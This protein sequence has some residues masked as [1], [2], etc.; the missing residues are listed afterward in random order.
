ML[1]TPILFIIFNRPE[2]TKLVF[3]II[4]EA[5]PTK[6]YVAS[7][8]PRSKNSNDL[9]LIEQSRQIVTAVD[10]KCDV[11]TLFQKENLGCGLGPRTAFQWFFEHEKLGIILEDD[12]LP[13]LD[14]FN[15]CEEM[16]DRYAN[17]KKII[18]VIGSN[19]GYNAYNKASYFFSRY[20]NT[21]GWATWKDRMLEIDFSISDWQKSK[22]KRLKAIRLLQRN[23]FDWDI[24]FFKKWYYIWN[25]TI[26]DK[27]VTWWDYQL[28]Y[29]QL[30]NRQYTIVPSKN[31]IKNIGYNTQGTH[32]LNESHPLS[33]LELKTLKFPLNHPKKIKSNK[34]FEENYLKRLWFWQ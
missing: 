23:I 21:V 32:T 10:W 18:N 4:R 5:R 6:L 11:K 14:F 3:E 22:F 19:L 9:P 12:G 2:T 13:N 1:K 29:N 31:L 27:N 7:D 26:A 20:I 8:G 15:F 28:I 17:N 24:M 30:M 33:N 25:K 16:L 34:H